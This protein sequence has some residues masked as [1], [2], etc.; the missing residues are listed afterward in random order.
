MEACRIELR[1]FYSD[2]SLIK[3]RN[4]GWMKQPWPK[5]FETKILVHLN[6]RLVIML[7]KNYQ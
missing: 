5:K 3:E 4:D 2:N 7:P 1:N 6:D